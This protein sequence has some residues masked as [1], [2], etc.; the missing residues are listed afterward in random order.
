MELYMLRKI[1]YHRTVPDGPYS[2]PICTERDFQARWKELVARV[3]FGT[4]K[5]PCPGSMWQ[6][7]WSRSHTRHRRHLWRRK[8][9][10]KFPGSS[11][12][13]KKFSTH[14][15]PCYVAPKQTR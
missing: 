8:F 4:S 15:G 5:Q 11:K 3:E 9:T 10:P 6:P 1:E 12:P 13:H 2:R 14:V 7:D